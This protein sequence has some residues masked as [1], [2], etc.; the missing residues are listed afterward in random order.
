MET[1]N[2]FENQNSYQDLFTALTQY[3]EEL[4]FWQ[5]QTTTITRMKII[6]LPKETM[7]LVLVVEEFQKELELEKIEQ[8]KEIDL[9]EV[10]NE[11][12]EPP[13][14]QVAIK[15]ERTERE[16][17]ISGKGSLASA[18]VKGKRKR[19]KGKIKR[20]KRVRK[21]NGGCPNF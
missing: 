3:K 10:E 7:S 12:P 16:K 1:D 2:S 8:S 5:S 11:I 15:T 21:Y 9:E 18:K 19:L 14:E 4:T 17:N 13:F 20:K 6:T